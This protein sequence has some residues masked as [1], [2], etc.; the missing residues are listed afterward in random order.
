MLTSLR[1]FGPVY[2][3]SLLGLAFFSALIALLPQGLRPTSSFTIAIAASGLLS[4]LAVGLAQHRLRRL[5]AI[6]LAASN[7]VLLKPFIELAQLAPAFLGRNL[8]FVDDLLARADS[9][10]GLDWTAYFSWHAAHPTFGALCR[11]AYLLWPQIALVVVFV[12]AFDEKYERL[13]RYLIATTLSLVAVFLIAIFTPSYGAYV[14]HGMR[15]AAHPNFFVQF[16]D[17]KPAYDALRAGRRYLCRGGSVRCDLVPELPHG[18]GRPLFVGPVADPRAVDDRRR[19]DTLLPRDPCAGRSLLRRHD[20][21]RRDRH[22]RHSGVCLDRPAADRQRAS[23][24]A[25]SAGRLDA[26]VWARERVRSR[27]LSRARR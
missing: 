4:I 15:A 26:R 27:H 17:F 5:S 23:P 2:L 12:L 19:A 13:A 6:A 14:Q 20:R 11:V 10:L 25:P 21:R 3:T 18:D 24:P 1:T 7:I 9:A 8:P 16:S 22:R